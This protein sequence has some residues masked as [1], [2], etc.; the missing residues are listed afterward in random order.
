M[1]KVPAPNALT[2]GKEIYSIVFNIK[3]VSTLLGFIIIFLHPLV[4]DLGNSL[5]RQ[6][7]GL[8]DF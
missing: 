7:A 2:P 4:I 6:C 5:K 1:F 8:A 3:Q